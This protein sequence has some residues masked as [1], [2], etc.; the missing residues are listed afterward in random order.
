MNPHTLNSTSNSFS[1]EIVMT[2]QHGI[3]CNW[4]KFNKSEILCYAVQEFM[5]YGHPSMFLTI[6]HTVTNFV[7]FC[8]VSWTFQAF[9]KMVSTQSLVTGLETIKGT[10]FCQNSGTGYWFFSQHIT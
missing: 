2:A 7:T 6:L 8:L 4:P 5:V 9:Q 1:I 10:K 3:T